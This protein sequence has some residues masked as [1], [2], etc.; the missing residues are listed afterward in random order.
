MKKSHK[1]VSVGAL[2][3]EKKLH[4]EGVG[5]DYSPIIQHYNV[6]SND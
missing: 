5:G 6:Y 4:V 3:V 2:P 1:K